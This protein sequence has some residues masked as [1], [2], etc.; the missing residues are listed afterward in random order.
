MRPADLFKQYLVADILK[1]CQRNKLT[2][3]DLIQQGFVV[4]GSIEKIIDGCEKPS[5]SS[6]RF[7][8]RSIFS[9]L[10]Q[11]PISADDPISPAEA[12]SCLK[13]WAVQAS[14]AED[15]PAVLEIS[16]K[17]LGKLAMPFQDGDLSVYA[18]A[19]TLSAVAA[20]L[21]GHSKIE[22]PLLLYSIDLSGIQNFIYSI[23]NKGALKGIK[24]RSFYLDILMEHVS[25]TLLEQVGFSRL[26]L[27]YCGGGK[28][29][30]LLPNCHDVI[31][32]ADE[33]IKEGNRFLQ[34]HFGTSLYLARGYAA[35]SLED[36]SSHGGK[37]PSLSN[38]FRATSEMISEKKIHRYSAS[39]L[40]RFNQSQDVDGKR[41]CAICGNAS[42]LVQRED[43]WLC[44]NC[45][46]FEQ[47]AQN[48]RT[49]SFK[50]YVYSNP[51]SPALPLPYGNNLGL[52]ASLTDQSPIRV[53]S[54]NMTPKEGEH[55]LYIGNYQPT[56]DSTF[57]TLAAASQ[58]I[59]RLGVF[60]MDVDNLGTL[61]ANG[62]KLPD[63]PLPYRRLS[64]TRYSMLSEA[65]TH[66]FKE[67]INSIVKQGALSHSLSKT[68]VNRN[69]SIVYSGGDDV[70]L[71][72]AWN[73]AIDAGLAIKEAFEQYTG[74]KVTLSGGVGIFQSKS[75]I[76][77]M[78][79]Y[80]AELEG[81]AK[82]VPGKNSVALLEGRNAFSWHSYSSVILGEMLPHIHSLAGEDAEQGNSFLY[83]V[84]ELLRKTS[85]KSIEVAR[86]AYL[87]SKNRPKKNY[88][89]YDKFSRQVYEWA[90]NS[91][92]NIQLQTAIQL[93]VYL[94]R[95]GNK[96]DL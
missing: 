72:G 31:S 66:F 36:L 58:G 50:L 56:E 83:H 46:S 38:L 71:A 9:G 65:L 25:D 49:S 77:Q 86:L 96:N 61:F 42:H 92:R 87:L 17:N 64:L 40:I 63:D 37:E 60:R 90:L 4:D 67:E 18:H 7:G 34:K 69:V 29:H 3:P 54:V 10:G 8:V 21:E 70:F 15:L 89:E 27:I 2:V 41:E 43:D 57:E 94:N 6:T 14:K 19:K 23:G 88:E 44:K 68:V 59:C 95:E 13:A 24:T 28:A 75:P 22:K 85:G 11:Y 33:L 55:V 45:L 32:K 62:F 76:R 1:Y 52:T 35:A 74:G 5:S 48:L 53:Y 47:F 26:N 51:V 93:Y 20:C 80:C 91:E 16:R 82:A 30:L 73:E 78:A 39:E 12:T 79:S 84:I 81:A